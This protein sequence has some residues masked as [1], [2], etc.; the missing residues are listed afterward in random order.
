MCLFATKIKNIFVTKSIF[1]ASNGMKKNVFFPICSCSYHHEIVI[2]VLYLQT[3]Y[4]YDQTVS[5]QCKNHKKSVHKCQ[6]VMSQRTG[7][8]VFV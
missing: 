1:I 7:F 5:D 2:S 3:K 6:I 8:R 4:P